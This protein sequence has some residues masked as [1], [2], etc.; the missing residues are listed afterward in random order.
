M[1]IYSYSY[2]YISLCIKRKHTIY[3]YIYIYTHTYICHQ[4]FHALPFLE[5]GEPAKKTLPMLEER[6]PRKPFE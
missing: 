2:I 6:L 5:V 4:T 3:I 1:H